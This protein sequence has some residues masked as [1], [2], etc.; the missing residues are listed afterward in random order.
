[1]KSTVAPYQ[2]SATCLRI[3]CEN[4]TTIRLTR[5]PYDLT[6]SNGQ[7]YATASAYDFSSVIAETS[8]AASAIDLE[9]FVAVGGIT[10]AQIASGVFDGA[11]CYLF[12]CNFLS[13]VEDYEPLMASILGKT[14]LEDDR[15]RIE[16]MSLVDLLNQTVG[17]TYT[18]ACRKELGGQGYGGCKVD[19]TTIDVVGA[20]TSIA[21]SLA[22]TDS[23]RAEAND[24]FGWG[25]VEFT[26][27]DNAGLRPLRVRDFSAGQFTLYEPP[28]YALT[29]GNTYVAIPGCRKRLEDCRDK[30]G[31]VL[32]FGGFPYVPTGSQYRTIGDGK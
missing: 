8:F 31:N 18:A 15:F 17:E 30:F 3:V 9:G 14:Q 6:M 25:T 21:S 7:V 12:A 29:I 16:D 10:R 28:Y 23:S 27:G 26:S 20:V 11:R 13:P 4:G 32:R 5:Y 1:M 22:F 19:L 2:T 24:Y